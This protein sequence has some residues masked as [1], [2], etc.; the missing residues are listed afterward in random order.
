MLEVV[1]V[2]FYD[3]GGEVV[4]QVHLAQCLR[5]GWMKDCA[6]CA[7]H[8]QPHKLPVAA[9]PFAVSEGRRKHEIVFRAAPMGG[10]PLLGRGD[11]GGSGQEGEQ[12]VGQQRREQLVRHPV[13]KAPSSIL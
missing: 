5:D 1:P 6:K 13:S 7:G 3:E 10:E 12:P 9:G 8:V 11:E 2:D 4:R